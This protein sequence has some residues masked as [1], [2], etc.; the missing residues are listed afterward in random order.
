MRLTYSYK[1]KLILLMRLTLKI[2]FIGLK[3]L[4]SCVPTKLPELRKYHIFEE[5]K[6]SVFPL[7]EKFEKSPTK[8]MDAVDKILMMG[9]LLMQKR[10][11][12]Q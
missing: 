5:N 8:K 10:R 2:Y 9:Y 3:F 12:H 7:K 4:I 6:N 1:N 11:N